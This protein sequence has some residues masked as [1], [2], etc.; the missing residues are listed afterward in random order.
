MACASSQVLNGHVLKR[1]AFK[2][3]IL[4]VSTWMVVT[5]LRAINITKQLKLPSKSM[6]YNISLNKEIHKIHPKTNDVQTYTSLAP[7]KVDN[8]EDLET[9]RLYN[10]KGGMEFR[11][12]LA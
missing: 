9:D 7:E 10:T 1:H 4:L 3:V 6:Y 5:L 2:V 11:I 8:D 12:Y